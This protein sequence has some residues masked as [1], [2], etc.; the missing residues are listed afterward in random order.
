MHLLERDFAARFAHWEITLPPGTVER[1]AGGRIVHQGWA[2]WYLVGEDERGVYLD[3]YA[4]HRMTN[5]RHHRLREDGTDED[6]PTIQSM[7]LVS[8]DPEEDA[9][10]AAEHLA[11]NREV[12]R[13]LEEKGFG[14]AGDEPGSV[15]VN[16]WLTLEG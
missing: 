2:I 1:R 3:Y 4:A 13:M 9:R 6:L 7:R 14:M 5:D 11:G 15:Q 12:A 16:R 10:R 8:P